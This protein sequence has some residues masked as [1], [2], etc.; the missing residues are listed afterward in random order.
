[1]ERMVAIR[2]A[3]QCG[4]VADKVAAKLTT[5]SRWAITL[6]LP[7][8]VTVSGNKK[9]R[10]M[11]QGRQRKTWIRI[12]MVGA[13]LQSGDGVRLDVLLRCWIRDLGGHTGKTRNRCPYVWQ[14]VRSGSGVIVGDRLSGVLGTFWD[15][16]ADVSWPTSSARCFAW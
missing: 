16:F 6:V 9:K 2:C 15:G 14:L 7:R 10:Q 12:T 5:R 8:R 1:M 13:T 4:V 3:G 11:S